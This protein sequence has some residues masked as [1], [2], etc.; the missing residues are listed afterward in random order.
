M[1]ITKIKNYVENG[2]ISRINESISMFCSRADEL[3]SKKCGISCIVTTTSK[4]SMSG[5][6][7]ELIALVLKNISMN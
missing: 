5:K 3:M 6:N 1:N 7:S 2:D 4:T